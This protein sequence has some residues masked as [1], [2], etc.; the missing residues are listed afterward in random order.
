MLKSTVI[1]KKILHLPNE[2]L[3]SAR[4]GTFLPFFAGEKMAKFRAWREVP[5]HHPPAS[6]TAA[7]SHGGRTHL[8]ARWCPK[9]LAEFSGNQR[10]K[11]GKSPF[12]I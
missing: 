3:F 1:A 5:A 12:S 7:G 8:S 2:K 9:L 11:G 4:L 6:A 10:K